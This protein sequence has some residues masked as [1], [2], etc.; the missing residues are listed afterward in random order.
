MKYSRFREAMLS[1][2]SDP[3]KEYLEKE[4]LPQYEACTTVKAVAE[5]RIASLPDHLRDL[6]LDYVDKQKTLD[7]VE[8]T[9]LFLDGVRSISQAISGQVAHMSVHFAQQLMNAPK[10]VGADGQ[11]I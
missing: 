4:V 6:V 1:K 3:I 11:S 5:V 10:L 8:K 7:I 2:V 9:Y